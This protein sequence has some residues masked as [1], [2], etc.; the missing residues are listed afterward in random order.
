M[1]GYGGDGAGREERGGGRE[2]EVSG[3]V[4]RTRDV[5]GCAEVTDGNLS[6]A[7]EV[8]EEDSIELHG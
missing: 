7:E 1:A 4:E 3:I 2:G 8:L 5:D 6:R